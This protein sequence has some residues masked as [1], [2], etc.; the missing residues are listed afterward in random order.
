MDIDV[1]I[2]QHFQWKSLI[3][4]LFNDDYCNVLNPSMIAQDHD[5]DLGKWIHS[6][7][8]TPL[9][10]N[11]TFQNLEKSHK[12]FHQC[13]ARI[14][15]DYQSGNIDDAEQLL[16]RFNQTSSDVFHLLENLKKEL[17]KVDNSG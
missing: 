5:C 13:A 7:D 17:E 3:E 6:Q 15:L 4:S 11:K 9:S 14:V 2:H 8:S 10:K 16:P 12:K 1:I